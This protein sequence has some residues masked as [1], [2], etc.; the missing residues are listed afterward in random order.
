MHRKLAIGFFFSFFLIQVVSAQEKGKVLV[1]KDPQIDSLIAKR[2]E[3]SRMGS[4]GNTVTS[5]GFRVQIFSGLEREQAY[6]E[7][8]KFR[9]LYPTV[10][11]YISYTQ[12]NYRVR[13]GDFRTKLEAQKFLTEL[14][15]QYPSLFIFAEKINPR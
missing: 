3:L 1:I 6:A 11:T 5:L 10:R 9:A 12:P 4:S 2:L 8:T 14:K 13:V 15:K 7:Q